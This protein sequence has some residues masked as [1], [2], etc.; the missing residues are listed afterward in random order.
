MNKILVNLVVLI[1]G[2]IPFSLKGQT[3]RWLI[4]PQYTSI[5]SYGDAMYKVKSGRYVG[6][7]GQDGNTI[8]PVNAD[9]VTSLV[10]GCALV[11]QFEEDK[12]RLRGI[13]HNDQKLIPVTE[14]CYVDDY[15]FFSEGKLPVYA[16]NGKYGYVN[17][18]GVLVTGF[19]YSSVHPFSEGWAAVCKGK[20][21]VEKSF[22]QIKKNLTKNKKD[23]VFYINEQGRAMTFSSDI[24]DVYFGTSFKDGEALVITKDNKY[25]FINTL[26]QLIRI[27]DNV[28]MMFDE[29]FA[30]QT[31][32]KE[33]K[34]NTISAAIYDGPATFV[35][36]STYGYM[37]GG[38]VILPAQFTEAYPFS[39][40]Y[41]IAA[42]GKNYGV[43]KLLQGDFLCRTATG[44]LK[45]T[46]AEV[47]SVDYIVSVPE[48]WKDGTLEFYCVNADGK[49]VSS[50]Q[51]G[52]T[53]A[54][55]VFS[56]L[57]S[58]DKR[59]LS[60]EGENLLLWNSDMAGSATE[61]KLAEDDINISISPTTVKAN[62]KDN[63]PITVTLM[64]NTSGTIELTVKVTGDRLKSITKTIS[65]EGKQTEKIST[66]FT[67]VSKEEY[68]TVTVS[69]SL[70]ENNVSKRIKLLPFFVKY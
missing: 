70:T 21:L 31:G 56:F 15:P 2:F 39:K 45:T 68:R 57:L 43:L 48:D 8:V 50:S 41:A 16:K 67:K 29:K 38:K 69:T 18:N 34:N 55:R 20:G 30:L 37:L 52:N 47:E 40:G 4:K 63:A 3:A 11:L 28:T 46:D 54:S 22:G 61:S 17:S 27:D 6:I 58:K 10:E 65:I 14:E 23:K 9:S 66:Y 12:Y 33:V 13:L 25:C 26:G 59:D 19:D 53:N 7:L 60:L 51:P 35:E 5:S 1:C 64:N 24:G 44:T 62:V 49:K 36:N 42:K 32:D